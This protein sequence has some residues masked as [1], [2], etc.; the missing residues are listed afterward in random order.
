MLIRELT[1]NVKTPLNEWAPLWA[2]VDVLFGASPAGQWSDR[3]PA[4]QL[5]HSLSSNPATKDSAHDAA[6]EFQQRINKE[7]VTDELMKIWSNATGSNFAKSFPW[8]M[9]KVSVPQPGTG[10]DGPAG[11]A[12]PPPPP[13]VT[14]KAEPPKVDP[15]AVIAKVPSSVTDQ[16][17]LIS[18]LKGTKNGW[19]D[20]IAKTT[21]LSPANASKLVNYGI[22]AAG[23][24]A[25]LYG[26][27]KLW[28]Y[29]QKKDK[30]TAT[31]P[32]KFVT[33][34]AQ[35][36][37]QEGGYIN[38][39]KDAIETLGSLRG[40][41]KQLERGQQ[42]YEGNLPNEYVNDVWDVWTWIESKLGGGA[43]ANDPKLKSIMTDVFALR[44][45]AKK[46]ERIYK[47]DLERT[48]DHMGAAGFG[49]MVVNTL[50]PLMQWLDM[51]EK[52]F[53]SIA[54]ETAT[55]GATVAGNI[56]A[57]PSPDA[58][59]HKSKKRGKYGAPQAPQKKNKDGTAKNALD[60][61]NNIMGGKTIKR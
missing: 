53:E 25:L 27:K 39:T 20:G 59:Y 41:G 3:S 35:E 13:P 18:T 60:V 14:T 56:A 10:A 49:N 30:K 21:T 54:N 29:Y 37:I 31:G 61:S 55:A 1:N 6:L 33:A 9:P 32:A 57:V 15:K 44:G 40:K 26:G 34:S 58:A 4:S 46:M 2:A 11:G 52:K 45:E 50:Y 8:M 47:P 38:N 23:I 16:S 22:P 36:N 43:E 51:N 17:G 5:Y 28:D 12:K 7:G 48:D 42:E 19:I 24:L